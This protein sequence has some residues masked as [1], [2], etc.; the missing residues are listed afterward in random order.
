MMNILKE[1]CTQKISITEKKYE[2]KNML[3]L[4]RDQLDN[5]IS[6]EKGVII[7]KVRNE[8]KNQSINFS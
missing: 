4:K 7:Q 2:C 8:S 5:F 1:Y 6:V 3:K